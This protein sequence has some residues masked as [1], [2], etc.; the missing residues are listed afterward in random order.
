LPD[1]P[2]PLKKRRWEHS[3][4]D[5]TL[6]AFE[7][8]PVRI[9]QNMT[10][11]NRPNA[12]PIIRCSDF[13]TLESINSG[14]FGHIFKVRHNT[15]QE[16][17]ALKKYKK[18]FSSLQQ[19]TK[20]LSKLNN[21]KSLFRSNDHKNIVRH[22]AVWQED[23]RL[24]ILMEFCDSK[25]LQQYIHDQSAKLKKDLQNQDADRTKQM[26]TYMSDSLI[27]SINSSSRT[28]YDEQEA[29]RLINQLAS[30]LSCL[31]S[32][33]NL[34][35]CDVSPSNIYLHRHKRTHIYKL[36][37]LDG[38]CKMQK[39]NYRTEHFLSNNVCA[40]SIFSTM[41][42]TNSLQDDK[43]SEQISFSDVEGQY[44][45]PELLNHTSSNPTDCIKPS[46]DVFA[47]GVVIYT[48]V[49]GQKATKLNDNPIQLNFEHSL[50]QEP[51]S[52][53]LQN[54]ILKMTSFQ[55]ADRPSIDQILQIA[56]HQLFL[57]TEQ[58]NQMQLHN[59]LTSVTN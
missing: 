39:Q 36:G 46:I 23:N 54:L 20:R 49:T 45:A 18:P 34:L 29:W 42:G 58:R 52:S 3:F 5:H 56:E 16:I 57:T 43:F 33:H 4:Q 7:G 37:D 50:L 12:L 22:Y 41:S 38:I 14:S 8:C 19:R 11:N 13:T 25:D 15:T 51:V 28:L 53:T 1:T 26:S 21:L 9:S 55:A 59:T 35:H 30:A 27:K 48:F 47:L 10:G 24:H 17:Y 32:N 6:I 2:T 40:A 44:Q 31:H